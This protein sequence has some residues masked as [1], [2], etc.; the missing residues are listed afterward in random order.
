MMKD[1]GKIEKRSV[2]SAIFSPIIHCYRNRKKSLSNEQFIFFPFF[3]H[4]IWEL[5]YKNLISA[6]LLSVLY[7]WFTPGVCAFGAAA[8]CQ[9]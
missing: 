6:K 7:P 3:K 1:A 4:P 5:L 9:F 8:L 2:A